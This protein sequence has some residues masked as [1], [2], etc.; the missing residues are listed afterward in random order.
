[1]IRHSDELNVVPESAGQSSERVHTG[2]TCPDCSGAITAFRD[3]KKHLVFECR[4]GHVYTTAEFAAAKE[5]HAESVL[6]VAISALEE[7]AAYLREM[8][9]DPIRA[10]R[11]VEEASAIRRMLDESEPARIEAP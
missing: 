5:Q 2:I 11:L 10:R 8:D 7:L 1:M 9:L 6:W 4:I 3:G